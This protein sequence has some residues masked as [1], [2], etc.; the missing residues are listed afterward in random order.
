MKKNAH[1]TLRR[2]K[3]AIVRPVNVKRL[4]DHLITKNDSETFLENQDI[5]ETK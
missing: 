4:D 3:E 5:Y 2:I 1:R